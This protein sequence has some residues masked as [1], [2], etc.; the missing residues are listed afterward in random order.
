MASL[1]AGQGTPGGDHGGT[2]AVAGDAYAV[3][4]SYV[5]TLCGIGTSDHSGLRRA[6]CLAFSV[7]SLP[8]QF[9]PAVI[10]FSGK[11]R[12]HRVVS[13]ASSQLAAQRHGGGAASSI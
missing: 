1:L 7:A 9:L 8:F 3:I 5:G 11:A 2:W 13:G 6:G 12:E 4:A 10:A